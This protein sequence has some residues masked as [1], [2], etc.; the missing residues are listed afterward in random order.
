M[1]VSHTLL[2]TEKETPKNA[3]LISHQYMLRAGLIRRLA[4]G[5]YQWLPTGMKV[6]HKVQTIVREEME[7]AGACEVLMPSIL[8]AE[9]LQ[10]TNRWQK[11]G[12]ELLKMQDRHNRD[13]YYGPTHEEPIVDIARKEI[14]SYK[15][16]P[17]NLYQIQTKFRDEIRPRFGAMRA[18]E[19]I[20]KDAYS[21]HSND[22]CLENTYQIM[23]TAY[24]NILTRMGLDF[25]VVKADAGAIGGSTTHEFQ[26]LAAAGE[27]IICFSDQSDY[28]ANI[29]MAQYLKPDL[30]TRQKP[31]KALTKTA[32]PN[33]KTIADICQKF[34]L[35]A[36]QT[37][38]TIVIKDD[39][40]R[41][42]ALV[43]RG[44]HE[45]NDIKVEKLPQVKT[46]FVLANEQDIRQVFN[47][48]VGSL[49]PINSPVPVIV[50]YSAAML[51]N[52]VCGAN[53]DDFHFFDANWERDI[54]DFNLADIRNVCIGDLSPD[55]MGVLQQ[56]SGIEVGHIFQLGDHYSRA[57]GASI[58]DENGKKK[59]LIMGC[60]G[61]GV[62]RIIAA[63]IEQS[64][65]ENGII[66]PS[67]IAPYD[68]TIIPMNMHKSS[69]VFEVANKLYNDLRAAG[70]DVLFDD[71]KERPGIMFADADLIG[72]PHH[73]IIGERGLENDIIEHKCRKTQQ[74]QEIP[75]TVDAILQKVCAKQTS[76]AITT[77]LC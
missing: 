74:K 24:C 54:N 68:I 65:D 15:Q 37:I 39:D 48:N 17:L 61:F 12:P 73:L 51:H 40:D 69:K 16:L 55:G 30:T 62:S 33:L 56:T 7:K 50:D 70:F 42:F 75:A 67:E 60:Y 35:D 9:L 58:L 25:R 31:S 13:F 66:W 20:M 46:P 8:P 43:L 53:E 71:R 49:G 5:I 18:R 26:V 76:N 77:T 45:L 34:T 32:T 2:A 4:S 63:A 38:K 14:K 19:F 10:E 1:R 11:F 47:A 52:F 27:D 59:D 29:E 6:L 21:F 3:E 22:E 41:L 57:M 64:H 36:A 72:S 28:A 23:H 44:D